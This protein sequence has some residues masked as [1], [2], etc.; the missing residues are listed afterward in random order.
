MNNLPILKDRET[1]ATQLRN[2]MSRHDWWYDYS[3]DHGVW[4]KGRD[5]YKVVSDLFADLDV[6]DPEY[7]REVWNE[8]APDG[9]KFT[10]KNA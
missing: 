2:V 9:W 7:A 3:D 6:I 1:V 10:N 8:T 5:S 4:T